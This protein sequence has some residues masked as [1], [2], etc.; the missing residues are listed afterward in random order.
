MPAP[1]S[2][3]HQHRRDGAGR[4][5]HPDSGFTLVEVVVALGILALSLSVMFGALS[6]GIWHVRQADASARAGLLV[7]SLLARIG[8][9]VPLQ[10]GETSGQ[11]SDGFAW[12][13]SLQRFG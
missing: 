4:N 7:Q 11:F 6:S 10:E 3:D 2:H 1:S 13:L 5:K 12:K 8:T 9:E